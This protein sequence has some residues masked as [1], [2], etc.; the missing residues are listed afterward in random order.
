MSQG[1]F[2][3]NKKMG[4]EKVDKPKGRIPD[5]SMCSISRISSIED[6]E[7]ALTATE[8]MDWERQNCEFFP[9]FLPLLLVIS[10][11]QLIY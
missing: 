6:T 11:G 3:Q 1:S 10:E 2:I 5:Y 4:I 9:R 8:V 7:S